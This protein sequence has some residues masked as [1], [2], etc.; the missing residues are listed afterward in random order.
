MVA[1]AHRSVFVEKTLFSL[2]SDIFQGHKKL[3][4]FTHSDRR[5]H[6]I[7]HTATSNDLDQEP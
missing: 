1:C 7:K 4:P 2:K 3:F 5:Q 6:T